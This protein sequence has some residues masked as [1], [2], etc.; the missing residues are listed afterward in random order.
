MNKMQVSAAAAAAA[1]AAIPTTTKDA[2]A[3][4]ALKTVLESAKLDHKT[5]ILLEENLKY[6]HIYCKKYGLSGQVSGP[7]IENYI[8]HKYDMK[9][10]AA[11]A[12]CGDVNY[13]DKN[14]EI[15]VSNGGKENNKFNYVQLRMNHDCEYLL[16]AYYIDAANLDQLG[17]LFVFRLNKNQLKPLIV[18]YGGYAH[19][20]VHALGKITA[21]DLDDASNDKEYAIRPKYNDKCWNELLEFRVSD[22]DLISAFTSGAASA[23]GGESGGAESGSI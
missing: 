1:M 8:K 9:K 5:N 21:D 3:K 23:S 16:T 17:E 10:N 20:T 4:F 6:A 14:I 15:K 19:G 12:C 7:L 2:A 13:R 11:S 18:K 22:V